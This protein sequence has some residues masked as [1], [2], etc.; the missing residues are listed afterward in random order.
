MTTTYSTTQRHHLD[1]AMLLA[2]DPREADDWARFCQTLYA[3]HAMHGFISQNRVRVA[4]SDRHGLT[5]RPRTY[6]SYWLRAQRGKKSGPGLHEPFI[7][8]DGWE[9]CATSTSGNNGRPLRRYRWIGAD[10]MTAREELIEVMAR[11][12]AEAFG[13]DPDRECDGVPE[14]AEFR[15][16]A[17]AAVAEVE[18]RYSIRDLGELIARSRGTCP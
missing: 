12:M 6:S 7:E 3:D 1:I 10:A 15:P 17:R 18:A 11:G 14:W 4:L 5:I 16:D 9:V 8:A 13:L 2:T